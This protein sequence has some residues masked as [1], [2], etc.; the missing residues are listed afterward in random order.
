MIDMEQIQCEGCGESTPGHD[1]VSYGGMD[2]GYRQLCSR[3]FNAEVV[4]LTGLDDFE[5]FR[6]EPIGICDSAGEVHQFHFQVRLL[7]NIVA[8]DAFELRDGVP[9]GYQFQMVG[10]PEDDLLALLGRLIEKIRRRLS[11]KHLT[12][13]GHELQ[14]AEQTVRGRIDWDESAVERTPL[15]VIDGREITWDDFGRMLMAFEGWQFKLEIV[16]PSGEA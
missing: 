7:G 14:I 13:V 10:E 4:K 15:L 6:F 5:H 12:G 11:V 3:C 1:I 16:D 9:S 2:N 8:L